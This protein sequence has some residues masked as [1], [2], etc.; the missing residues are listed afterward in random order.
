MD[1]GA[2]LS[3][4]YQENERLWFSMNFCFQNAQHYAKCFWLLLCSKLCWHYLPRCSA[5]ILYVRTYVR[6]Q[7][8]ARKQRGNPHN[9]AVEPSSKARAET[10][11]KSSHAP[12]TWLLSQKEVVDTQKY[13]REGK[14]TGHIRNTMSMQGVRTNL[15]DDFWKAL[16]GGDKQQRSVRRYQEIPEEVKHEK[17]TKLHYW[18]SALN[19]NLDIVLPKQVGAKTFVLMASCFVSLMK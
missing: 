18:R 1:P 14:V 3:L 2:L 12:I 4:N 9:L 15:E 6:P 5:G 17:L 10:T 7:K 11:W 16:Q 13:M 19:S 8:H